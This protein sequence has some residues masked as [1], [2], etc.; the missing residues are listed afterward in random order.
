MRVGFDARW[1]NDSGVGTYVAGLLRA[2]ALAQ[3]DFELV[4]Y[5]DPRNPIPGLDALPASIIPVN[6]R[7][8]SVAEQ[9][10]LRRRAREDR[11]DVFHSPFFVTP[12]ALHCPLVVTFHDLIPFLFRI[13]GWPKQSLVKAGYRMVSRKARHII[14]VSH[15][16]A[17]DVQRILHVSPDRVSSVHNGIDR[18]CFC[19]R[20]RTDELEILEREYDIRPPYVVA[21]SARNWRTKN[22]ETA[23]EAISHALR[24]TGVPF[25]VLVYGP[26]DGFEVLDVKKRW[27]LLNLRLTGYL[28]PRDLAALFRHARAFIMPSLHE[29]FGLPV[30]EAMACGCPVITSNG[31]SLPEIA[32]YGA[33]MFDPFDP[34]GMAAAITGLITN[35]EN[36]EHWRAAAFERAADFTWERAAQQ[37]ISVYH[38]IHDRSSSA[39]G[40]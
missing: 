25:Q 30:V 36:F 29:G 4:V 35:Q 1:Y 23:L 12:L 38:R 7:K 33:Q 8:Y 34:R 16:T 14:A 27:P 21:T 32:G 6:A 10:E 17:V 15:S 24:S 39:A 26:R 22:L 13:Y 19:P 3:R 18:D 37:T 5:S 9:F 2:M 31:G 20:G 28:P 11:L 40:V